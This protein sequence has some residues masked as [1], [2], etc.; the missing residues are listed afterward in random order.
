[1]TGLAERLSGEVTSVAL[2]WRLV[3]A[4]G[5]VLGFT[6]HDSDLGVAGVTYRAR[7]GMTPSG[8][9]QSCDLRTDSMDVEG[10][11]SA[12]SI[13]ALDLESG[14]W[15]GAAV[16][17]F[18]CDWT[19]PDAGSITLMQGTIGDVSRPFPDRN[20]PFTAELL[21]DV[22]R[23]ELAVPLRVSP[24]CRAE[25]GDGRC[26]VDIEGRRRQVLVES[27]E[28]HRLVLGAPLLD[29]DLFSGGRIR[30]L[31]GVL[32]GL[33]WRIATLT[34]GDLALEEPLPVGPLASGRAWI[35]EGCDKRFR[36]C[37]E[38]FQNALAF[39]GE[40][41]VPGVDALLRYAEG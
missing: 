36:T 19:S 26:G 33:D 18:A 9:S 32:A 25:L 38:R 21:S 20:G 10:V 37:A 2:C 5:A 1:V 23:I 30:F 12:D 39:D 11:L 4:D 17:L 22:R 15:S 16:R 13:S 35:Q 41:H 14:R 7:P 24:M 31:D 34:G 28:G 27:G 6:S 8:V 3:R 40:P 29:G